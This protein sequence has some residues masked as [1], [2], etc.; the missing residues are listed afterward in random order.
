MIQIA[1]FEWKKGRE[2]PE[3]CLTHLGI[4]TSHEVIAVLEDNGYRTSAVLQYHRRNGWEYANGVELKAVFK[5]AKV[6]QW[7]YIPRPIQRWQES[8]D[9]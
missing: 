7:A 9:E 5:D 4:E 3:C 1:D 8:F 2:L 6:M